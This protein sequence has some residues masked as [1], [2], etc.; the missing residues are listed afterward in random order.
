MVEALPVVHAGSGRQRRAEFRNQSLGEPMMNFVYGFILQG[1][2][3]RPVDDPE[4]NAL[5][6][7]RNG[8]AGKHVE[9]IQ[10]FDQGFAE[11]DHR[12]HEAGGFNRLIHN[13][14]DIPG[15]RETARRAD[16]SVPS[17]PA[18]S[19]ISWRMLTETLKPLR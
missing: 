14:G 1:P 12:I 2:F 8:V 16:L 3:G 10:I 5:L 11:A 19:R 9:Q 15:C 18:G 17:F 6:P 13:N 4:G 7:G